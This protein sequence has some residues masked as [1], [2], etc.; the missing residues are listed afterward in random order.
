[1]N[2][3]Q[4]IFSLSPKPFTE[5]E[6]FKR[7]FYPKVSPELVTIILNDLAEFP[8]LKDIL[9]FSYQISNE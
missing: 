5:Q 6:I 4:K 8:V 1:V 9:L 3:K 2:L 7:F